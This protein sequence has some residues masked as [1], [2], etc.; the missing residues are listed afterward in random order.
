MSSW[1]GKTRGGVLGYK[2]FVW[3]LKNLGISF[4]Y[5]LLRFVVFYFVFASGK[6][7]TAIFDCIL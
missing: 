4:A 3:T 6:S 7:F 2:I 5:L 1:E